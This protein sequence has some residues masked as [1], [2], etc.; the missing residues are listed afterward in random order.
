MV[1]VF[2]AYG[3]RAIIVVD[4]HVH[5]FGDGHAKVILGG[6]D[7]FPQHLRAEGMTRAEIRQAMR[8]VVEQQAIM[9]ARWKDIHG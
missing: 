2:R 3:L 4:A 9:L 8:I 1:P 5:R 6:S 7:G